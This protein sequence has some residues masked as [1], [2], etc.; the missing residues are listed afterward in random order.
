MALTNHSAS[1]LAVMVLFFHGK[2]LHILQVLK[3]LPE[4]SWVVICK[5]NIQ[6]N[7][8]IWSAFEFWRQKIF[9]HVTA[10]LAIV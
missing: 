4:E 1:P 5:T 8:N 9:C 10:V 7:K 3:F 6:T 2:T